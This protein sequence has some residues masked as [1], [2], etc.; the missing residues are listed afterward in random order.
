LAATLECVY[1]FMIREQMEV[2]KKKISDD[3]NW[4]HKKSYD[5]DSEGQDTWKEREIYAH[6]KSGQ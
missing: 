4:S 2:D 6:V 5:S 3:A 1:E